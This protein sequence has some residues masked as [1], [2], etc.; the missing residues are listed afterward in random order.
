[1]VLRRMQA[2]RL[3]KHDKNHEVRRSNF[4]NVMVAEE[5]KVRMQCKKLAVMKTRASFDD[6]V[7]PLCICPFFFTVDVSTNT[8]HSVTHPINNDRDR[9][10]T[11]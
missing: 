5:R 7:C 2:F 4:K 8:S 10:D 9:Y 6:K 11:L 3:E 1:M